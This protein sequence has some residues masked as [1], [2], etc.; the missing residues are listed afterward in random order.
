MIRINKKITALREEGTVLQHR[1]SFLLGFIK[2]ISVDISII[3]PNNVRQE[4]ILLTD[5][6]GLNIIS[7]VEHFN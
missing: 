3:C 7:I 2:I 1:S 4:S 5:L 6:Y